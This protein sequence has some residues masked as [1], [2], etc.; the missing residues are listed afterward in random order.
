MSSVEEL[1]EVVNKLPE[2]ISPDFVDIDSDGD[3]DFFVGQ[4]YTTETSP[5]MGRLHYF[6]NDGF[7]HL[8]LTLND[9]EFLGQEIGLSSQ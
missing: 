1:K 3:L 4:D 2:S 9:P 8:T 5:T 7:E 6:S